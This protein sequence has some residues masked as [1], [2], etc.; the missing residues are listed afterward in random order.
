MSRSATRTIPLPIAP[1]I[2]LT[3]HVAAE[4]A[5]TPRSASSRRSQ[6]IVGGVG[7]PAA[8]SS[9][10]GPRLVDRALE[11]ARAVDAADAVLLGEQVQRVHRG[12]SPA[13]ATRGGARGR[14]AGPAR[15]GRTPSGPSTGCAASSTSDRQRP[16]RRHRKRPVAAS[17][18]RLQ[19][20]PCVPGPRGAEHP[21]AQP[22]GQPANE[23]SSTSGACPPAWWARPDS[24][25]V[26]V[27][28]AGLNS[29]GSMS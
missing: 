25:L 5:R 27:T 19:Q 16:G 14:A 2:G 4:R 24:V 1:N 18:Q 3:T 9:G 26:S 11:R 6:T 20:P 13:P 15:Q 28:S 21:D 23:R 22:L 12:R 7:T 10:A 8:A 29:S 17:G